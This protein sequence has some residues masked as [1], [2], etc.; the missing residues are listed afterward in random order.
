M[1]KK[2]RRALEQTGEVRDEGNSSKKPKWTNKQRVLIFCSRGITHRPRHLMNDL[3]VLLPHSKADTKLDRKDQLFIVNEVCEMKNCNKCIFLEM[4]KKQDAYMW[5]SDTPHGPSAKFLVENI[6]TMDELKLTGNCLKGSRPILSFDTVF[7]QIPHYSLLKELFTQVFSTPCYHPKSKPFVDH[8]FNFS[9]ADNRIWFRNYQI[10]EEDLSLVEIGP[11]FVLNIIRI[12]E[13]SFGGICLY[14]NPLYRSP[15]EH[16]RLLK[17]GAGMK[18]RNRVDAR[19]A[20][21]ARQSGME[22]PEDEVEQVFQQ[23][24]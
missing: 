18:F 17:Q 5:I 16:R 13:G 6:H 1:A 14:E 7:D 12:F 21:T 3:R 19:M 2:R 10:V 23:D 11:R 9:I 22:L 20:F 24:V 15:N 4:R 8:V